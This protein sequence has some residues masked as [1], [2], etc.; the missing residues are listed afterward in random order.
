MLSA[1]EMRRD[2]LTALMSKSAVGYWL[3][4]RE[5]LEP[6]RKVE[7]V[8][9]LRLT[10]KGLGTC[11]SSAAGGSDT[12]TSAGLISAKRHVMKEGGRGQA[13]NVRSAAR[14]AAAELIQLRASDA[15]CAT[16]MDQAHTLCSPPHLTA[17]SVVE[18]ITIG[19]LSSSGRRT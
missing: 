9:M 5:W 19:V 16:S 2:V 13:T 17:A 4:Q 1:V 15:S 8:Q 3:N 7:R 10:D 14:V 12:R 11:A 18:S 6:V